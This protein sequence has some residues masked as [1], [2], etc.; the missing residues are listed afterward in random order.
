MNINSFISIV[1]VLFN[2]GGIAAIIVG[3]IKIISA[4]KK[5]KN[6]RYR[7]KVIAG[8]IVLAAVCFIIPGFISEELDKSGEYIKANHPA[9]IASITYGQVF[10]ELCA[11]MEWSQ[12]QSSSSSSELSFVQLDADCNYG[13]EERKITI[14]F[15]Y[16]MEDLQVIDENTP[17]EITFVGFD[18]EEQTSTET[19]QELIYSMFE[20]YAG[21]NQITVD[22]S[23]KDD[24]LHTKG[25][26]VSE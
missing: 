16:G 5:G 12:V 25:W 19:M 1:K 4:K 13:G 7:I 20:Y 11:N 18:G 9:S 23:M 6:T 8:T 17:F 21:Q 10:D 15:N 22:E 2:L 24:I 14:Q 3:I 26:H